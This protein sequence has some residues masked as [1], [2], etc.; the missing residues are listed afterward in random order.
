[1]ILCC[2][3]EHVF[4]DTGIDVAGNSCIAEARCV[5]RFLAK[6]RDYHIGKHSSVG[7]ATNF[8]S[9]KTEVLYSLDLLHVLRYKKMR[10]KDGICCD[11]ALLG[12]FYGRGVPTLVVNNCSSSADMLSLLRSDSVQERLVACGRSLETASSQVECTRCLLRTRRV[13]QSAVSL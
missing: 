11:C 10:H 13:A 5:G 1:M 9:R 2:A 7:R 3:E 4:V 8:R 6:L 12:I